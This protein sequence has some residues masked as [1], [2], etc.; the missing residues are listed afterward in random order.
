MLQS[1]HVPLFFGSWRIICSPFHRTDYEDVLKYELTRVF[2]FFFWVG[3]FL[4]LSVFK[5]YFP[6]I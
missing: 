6:E 1:L 3:R 4:L 5:N 2:F